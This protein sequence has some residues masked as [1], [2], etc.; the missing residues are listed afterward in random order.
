MENESGGHPQAPDSPDKSGRPSALPI[1]KQPVRGRGRWSAGPRMAVRSLDAGGRGPCKMDSNPGGARCRPHFAWSV[2]LGPGRRGNGYATA[3][4]IDCARSRG[5]RGVPGGDGTNWQVM[6]GAWLREKGAG[7]G[8]GG[9]ALG[10]VCPV[11]GAQ[12]LPRWP[13]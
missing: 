8:G 9:G 11:T 7:E 12:R 3:G 10:I 1:L 2:A 6:P 5:A 13:G 4:V